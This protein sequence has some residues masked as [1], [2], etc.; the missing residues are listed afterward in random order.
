MNLEDVDVLYD[1]AK[2]AS[3]LMDVVAYRLAEYP[4][5]P[6]EGRKAEIQMMR[7]S[8]YAAQREIL[9]LLWGTL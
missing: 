3:R 1:R 9:E 6:E 5:I 4:K 2:E 8:L 7:D